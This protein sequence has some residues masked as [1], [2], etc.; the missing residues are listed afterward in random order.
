MSDEFYPENLMP[1]AS[2]LEVR[3]RRF[4]ELREQ[5]LLDYGYNTA[6]AYWSDLDSICI[7]AL[8]RDKDPLELSE[9]DIRQYVAL[10]RR[11]K[12]SE[13]TVRRHITALRKLYRVTT[14]QINAATRVIIPARD[15]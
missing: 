1:I 3:Y 15:T 9:K 7:W 4:S 12:Y 6:R 8:E 11:R 5:V 2:Q 14:G 13:S 10:L